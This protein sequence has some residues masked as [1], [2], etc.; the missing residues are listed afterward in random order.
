MSESGNRERKENP[1]DD[2]FYFKYCLYTHL[3]SAYISSDRLVFSL[4]DGSRVVLIGEKN[5]YLLHLY[6]LCFAVS[7]IT[8]LTSF[9][10]FGEL[11]SGTRSADFGQTTSV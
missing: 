10:P 3:C 6:S 7:I 5:M 4:T 9:K 1:L 2:T 11:H 8:T